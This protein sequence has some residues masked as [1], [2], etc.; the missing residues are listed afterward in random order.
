MVIR[1]E[2]FNIM[3]KRFIIGLVVMFMATMASAQNAKTILDA[4]SAKYKA[5]HS[6]T[7]N[8]DYTMVNKA[9]GINDTFKGSIAVK[10]DMY[11]LKMGGQEVI[12]NG[13]TVWT[14]LPDDNEVNID[15]HSAEAG[16]ITPSSIYTIYQK[17]FT[18]VIL[19]PV[20]IGDKKYD[21]VDLIASDKDAQFYKIRLEIAQVDKTLGKFTMYDNEGSEFSYTISNFNSEV[22]L[23]DSDFEFDEAKHKGVEVID[24]R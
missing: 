14:Y 11:S 2:K 23:N 3:T 21:V 7:S 10:G 1:E 20:T 16:D 5:I 6:F 18:Y 17:G 22:K 12:N 8:I 4:M 15:N 9:D 19:S 24:L 13:T